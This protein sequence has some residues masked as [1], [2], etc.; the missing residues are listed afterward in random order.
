M[1]GRM[2]GACQAMTDGRNKDCT[3]H[4]PCDLKPPPTCTQT[5]SCVREKCFPLLLFLSQQK[6]TLNR[7]K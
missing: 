2:G 1:G 4:K 3:L 5:P 7:E 6:T